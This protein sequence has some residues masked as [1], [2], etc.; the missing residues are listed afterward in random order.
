MAS[1][2]GPSPQLG[3]LE[4]RNGALEYHDAKRA[5]RVALSDWRL[6]VGAWKQNE[7][8][9]V[10]TKFNLQRLARQPH[11]AVAID[12]PQIRLKTTP[13]A[14]SVAKFQMQ[15]GNATIGGTARLESLAPLRARG[16]LS[17]QTAS[18]RALL[19]E[20]AIG[21]PRPLDEQALGPLK[22]NTQWAFRGG[23]FAAKPI[24]L[25][26][27]E[28]TYDGEVTRAAGAASILRL[29]LHGDRIALDRYVR[30]A[31]TNS[32]PFE[33][34]TA[35]LKA[36]RLDGALTFAEAQIAGARVRNARIRLETP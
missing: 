2:G 4:I 17:A 20:L 28:T 23:A 25:L 5:M 1:K 10:S 31:D 27:D 9:S 32:E 19:A 7:P 36:L 16:D 12:L 34:P 8:F 35:A 33:L 13:F 30:L 24:R 14:A 22:L 18:L 29:R 21:G 11:I 15:L 6:D 26:L 3:G